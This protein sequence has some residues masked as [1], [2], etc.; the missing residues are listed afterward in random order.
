LPPHSPAVTPLLAFTLACCNS[1]ALSYSLL[2]P[3]TLSNLTLLLAV[4]TILW[5]LHDSKIT[6]EEWA[7]MVCRDLNLAVGH[8]DRIRNELNEQIASFKEILY[9]IQNITKYSYWQ[10]MLRETVAIV[11]LIRVQSLEFSDSLE[12]DLMDTQLTPVSN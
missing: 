3:P 9:L 10:V 12:W 8:R 4:N 2:I 6:T 1:A 7:T 11:L 5:N